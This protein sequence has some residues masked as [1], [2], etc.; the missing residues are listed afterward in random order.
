ML[1]RQQQKAGRGGVR[2]RE[3][4]LLGQFP[5]VGWHVVSCPILDAVRAKRFN[6]RKG[7]FPTPLWGFGSARRTASFWAA[8]LA[9]PTTKGEQQ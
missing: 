3:L 4:V 1:Q 2:E 5:W 7:G 9:P 8:S 6:P